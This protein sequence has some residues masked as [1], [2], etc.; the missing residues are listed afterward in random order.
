MFIARTQP[1]RV[2]SSGQWSQPDDRD[3]ARWGDANGGHLVEYITV[4]EPDGETRKITLGPS[5]RAVDFGRDLAAELP[6][7]ELE[8]Q[9][10]AGRRTVR[11]GN[12]V[13]VDKL[14]VEVVHFVDAPAA[15]K[16]KAA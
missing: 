13:Q 12:E 4:M 2:L 16:A 11:G 1:V 10:K 5:V 7:A 3:P 8:I 6:Y 15:A 14:R 9:V